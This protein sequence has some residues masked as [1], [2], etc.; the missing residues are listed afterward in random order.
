MDNLNKPLV[1]VGIPFYN[2]EK[3]LS[4]AVRTPKKA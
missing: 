3:Y 1:T 2:S 4:D